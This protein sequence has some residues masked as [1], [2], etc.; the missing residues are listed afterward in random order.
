MRNRLITLILALAACA[1][2]FGVFYSA[3][4]EPAAWRRAVRERDAMAWL[5]AEFHLND[6]QFAAVRQLH[7]EFGQ[8]CA[9]HCARIMEARRRH[10]SPA[11]IAALEATC[12]REM[13]EHFRR[14]AALMPA[15]EGARYLATVL[16]RID[17]F[18]HRGPPTV[19]VRS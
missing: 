6:A 18:D 10:D 11:A 12:V 16:P 2:A 1:A 15:G 13:R 14:V 19:Q 7:E 17:D 4:R 8:R 3:N 9:E 5:R